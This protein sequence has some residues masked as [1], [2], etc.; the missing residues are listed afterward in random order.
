MHFDVANQLMVINAGKHC[1]H[2]RKNALILTNKGVRNTRKTS[3]GYPDVS[4]AGNFMFAT[5]HLT[6]HCASSYT[7][8]TCTFATATLMQPRS[9]LTGFGDCLRTAR[10]LLT[11][12]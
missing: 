7:A 11:F 5:P 6:L 12:F 8:R 9:L 10:Y 2:R 4:Q 3:N 1:V